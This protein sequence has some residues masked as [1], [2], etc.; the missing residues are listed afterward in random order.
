MDP[1]TPSNDPATSST[2]V[3][4][5]RERILAAPSRESDDNQEFGS[6][7]T[8]LVASST[9]EAKKRP[10]LMNPSAPVDCVDE[11][12]RM[13]EKKITV[14]QLHRACT[15]FEA[16]KND[17]LDK[18][19]QM[20]ASRIRPL[21]RD[22]STEPKLT[23]ACLP[24]TRLYNDPVEAMEDILFLVNGRGTPEVKVAALETLANMALPWDLNLGH[25]TVKVPNF[26][27]RPDAQDDLY[28]AVYFALDHEDSRVREAGLKVLASGLNRKKDLA[29]KYSF[30]AARAAVLASELVAVDPSSKVQLVAL[31]VLCAIFEKEADEVR[32]HAVLPR[33][34]N[35]LGSWPPLV[36][37]ILVGWESNDDDVRRATLKVFSVAQFADGPALRA[38]VDGLRKT[39][40]AGC[41]LLREL[42]C[43]M[44][45]LGVRCGK[46][47]LPSYLQK[48]SHM[49]PIHKYQCAG[50]VHR[51]GDDARVRP[52][53]SSLENTPENV[54]LAT[55]YVGATSEYPEIALCLPYR[56]L[57]LMQ[58]IVRECPTIP[59]PIKRLAFTNTLLEQETEDESINPHLLPVLPASYL[60]LESGGR[61][62]RVRL[63]SHEVENKHSFRSELQAAID[64]ARR[65][66]GTGKALEHFYQKLSRIVCPRERRVCQWAHQLLVTYRQVREVL[67]E[68]HSISTPGEETWFVGTSPHIEASV[69]SLLQLHLRL[70]Q[71]YEFEER[72]RE[73]L[74]GIFLKLTQAMLQHFKPELRGEDG[75]VAISSLLPDADAFDIL[76][77]HKPLISSAC[78]TPTNVVVPAKL[79]AHV[80]V[81]VKTT[82]SSS[83]LFLRFVYPGVSDVLVPGG[84]TADVSLHPGET[85][86]KLIG[87]FRISLRCATVIPVTLNAHL[88]LRNPEQILCTMKAKVTATG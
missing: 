26:L 1:R 72:G 36:S 3:P 6:V 48:K 77:N 32:L 42:R 75:P 66:D 7:G 74:Q 40:E 78:I 30:F 69:I 41:S 11:L 58:R 14:A 61:P 46:F 24:L 5:K 35:V 50:L 25:R 70:M 15:I 57:V 16:E 53:A 73:A 85:S 56:M 28:G 31:R 63:V 54:L 83:A 13:F 62:M 38:A 88:M 43:L 21:L 64:E 71:V 52:K 67:P 27:H 47:Y 87:R 60:A 59:W 81:E 86:G 49:K 10:R 79:Y 51:A 23:L 37:N 76:I 8:A 84:K 82:I 65:G 20:I 18:A 17:Y 55:F 22:P 80:K 4:R 39:P 29:E 12:F 2:S 19:R 45:K 34:K 44:I 33:N 68:Y 9:K